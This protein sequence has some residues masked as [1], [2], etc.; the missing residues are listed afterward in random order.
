MPI[1]FHPSVFSTFLFY[2]NIDRT[3]PCACYKIALVV[4][5]DTI[6][7]PSPH[8]CMIYR[9]S[10]LGEEFLFVY[11]KCMYQHQEEGLYPSSFPYLKGY[12]VVCFLLYKSVW[13]LIHFRED[14]QVFFSS[15]GISCVCR[16]LS[17]LF[18]LIWQIWHSYPTLFIV[19]RP[20]VTQK[21]L[22]L[23]KVLSAFF[24]T[25]CR[26]CAKYTCTGFKV[27]H[28]TSIVNS[29]QSIIV[30]SVHLKRDV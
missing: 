20:F 22:F 4:V 1:Y 27:L 24:T 28:C 5:C 8:H 2:P 6:D 21:V 16:S 17:F 26:R 3:H 14:S 15:D 7:I 18:I 13:N 25:M 19:Y 30:Y 29:C 11:T 9:T 12:F 10:F 23:F